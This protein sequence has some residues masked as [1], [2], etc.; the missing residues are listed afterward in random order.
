MVHF[1]KKSQRFL[2]ETQ[3]IYTD[4]DLELL[5]NDRM[6]NT[7]FTDTQKRFAF[8]QRNYLLYETTEY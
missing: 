7:T 6:K 5:A 4:I 8:F 3:L 2:K 1:K